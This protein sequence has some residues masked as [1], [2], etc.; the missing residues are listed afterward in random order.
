MLA[1]REMQFALL[2]A[3]ADQFEAGYQAESIVFHGLR[4]MGKTVFLREAVERLRSRGWL[5]GYYS[6][7]HRMDAGVAVASLLAEAVPLLPVGSRLAR[8]AS[9]L[10]ARI[11]SAT[12][13]AGTGGLSVEVSASIPE[14]DLYADLVDVLRRLGD[15]ARDDGAG[16]AVVIDEMQALRLGDMA[17]LVEALGSV[18]ASDGLPVVLVGAGLPH[19]PT[20]LSKACTWAERLRYESVGR[21]P[22]QAARRALVEPAAELDVTY[23]PAAA[24]LLLNEADG[25]PFFI[26]LYASETWRAAGLPSER[27]GTVIDVDAV[28]SAVPEVKRILASGMYSARYERASMGEREYLLVMA[29][30]ASRSEDGVA[31]SGAIA[32]ELGRA[33]SA[34]SPTRDSLIRKGI[35]YSP[36]KG[37]LEFSVPGFGAY[38][39]WKGEESDGSGT[40]L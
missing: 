19:L 10:T 13:T 26:Q 28:A 24:D 9:K 17:A 27:P 22:A 32:R 8:F 25:Y 2:E 6:V 40:T 36:V 39:L 11:G 37:R 5:C 1:G 18:G 3:I 34:L 21:L 16:V 4:G 7:R 14:R 15:K 29:R 35:I 20:E 33:M 12:L 30:L 38:V 23:S 31:S